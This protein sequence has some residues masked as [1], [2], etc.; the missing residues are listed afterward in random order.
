MRCRLQDVVWPAQLG[1][2]GPG[3]A[4]GVLLG[5]AHPEPDGL[6]LRAENLG[7]RTDRL[8]LGPVFV[9]VV[10]DH[11][12]RAFTQLGGVLPRPS[13]FCHGSILSRVGA[14]TDPGAVH[15]AI[16]S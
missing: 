5:L 8:P 16:W 7:N 14:S 2:L 15:L 9:A 10:E 11:P 13:L 12:D 6:G 3:T 1:A 4:A